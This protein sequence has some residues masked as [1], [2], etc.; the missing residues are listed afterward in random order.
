MDDARAD[1]SVELIIGIEERLRWWQNLMYGV[2]QL[3]VD[4]T[5]LIVPILLARSL[6][7]PPETSAMLVQAGLIGAG[8]VTIG[9]ALWILKL[10]VLQ[11][12]A[13]VFV[14]VVPAVVAVSGLAAAWTG[15]VIAS[16]IAA[17]LSLFGIWGRLRVIFGAAPV[18]GVVIL[19]VSIIIA[20]TIATQIVGRP[21]TPTF[22]LPSNFL[23]AAIPVLVAMLVVLL[24]PSSFLRLASLL[25]G[26]VL[27]I[28]VAILFGQM[29]FEA[30]AKA[31]W[32]GFSVL[33]PFGFQFDL[34]TTIVMFIAFVADLGQV[35]GSYVLV[36]EVIGKQKVSDKRIDGGVL[37]ESIGSVVSS[38]LGGL[39]TVTYNQNIGALMVTGI[40]SR[41][42]FATAGAIL[43]VL[44]LCPK[45]GAVIASIPGPIV[46]GLLLITIAMLCMQAIRVLGTM[47]QTNANLFAAGMGIVIGVG[48]TVLPRDLLMMVPELFRPFVS[49]GIIMGF[50]VAGTIHT[51]FN[52][53]MKSGEAQPSSAPAAHG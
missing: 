39:P 36:G 31:P 9:Q 16:L 24:I 53:L 8:L 12:P 51:I 14:S 22:A 10:P 25:F 21:G 19:L 28:A 30:V 2:Q 48:I 34:G 43:V 6:Q 4:T 40:G 37:T 33:F 15:L 3:T 35:I 5:I 45:I 44:G 50:L 26:A 41:Y 7:L 27:A 11:G 49:S 20:G 52:V 1:Q 23:L 32:F 47:P 38:A 17:V 46:G 18:Y 13:I 29:S 42:V